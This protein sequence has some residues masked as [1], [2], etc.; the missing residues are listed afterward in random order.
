MMQLL[1]RR[2]PDE[3]K[4]RQ[5]IMIGIFLEGC[6]DIEG[7]KMAVT[8]RNPP[9]HLMPAN[10]QGLT[11]LCQRCL[12]RNLRSRPKAP[13]VLKDPWFANFEAAEDVGIGP[14]E[15]QMGAAHPLAT[16]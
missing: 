6:R 13:T 4:A 12:D 14:I 7:V 9:Y 15:A 8:T 10:M 11:R 16:C 5:G 1:T 2:V 3:D